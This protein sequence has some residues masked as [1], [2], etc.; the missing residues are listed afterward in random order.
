V[1]AHEFRDAKA[2]FDARNAVIVGCSADPPATQGRFKAKHKLNF[3]L[4]SD[5]EK[6]VLKA[7]GVWQKKSFL[8]KK[9]M[10]IVRSTVLIGPDGTVKKVFPKVKPGQHAEEVLAALS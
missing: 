5:T 2:K 10:G 4:L 1:E 8:G 7:Y 9:F 6:E 3:T